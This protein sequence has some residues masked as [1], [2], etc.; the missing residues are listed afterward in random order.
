MNYNIRSKA[1]SPGYAALPFLISVTPKRRF[2][3]RGVAED[4]RFS[5]TKAGRFERDKV[6]GETMVNSTG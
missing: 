5:A 4:I 6:R 3:L 1:V 2:D